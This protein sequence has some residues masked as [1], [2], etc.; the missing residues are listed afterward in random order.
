MG[1]FDLFF[2]PGEAAPATIQRI[3]QVIRQTARHLFRNGGTLGN[4]GH[5]RVQRI[6]QKVRLY[7]QA[8]ML[9]LQ[10]QGPGL[11]LHLGHAFGARGQFGRHAEVHQRPNGKNAHV[12]EERQPVLIAGHHLHASWREH[13][14]DGVGDRRQQ[15]RGRQAQ[16]HGADKHQDRRIGLA[17]AASMQHG[18]R[19]G[20][21][22]GQRF[23]RQRQPDRR[24]S[25]A[26]HRHSD[27]KPDDG[28]EDPSH[29]LGAPEARRRFPL[30]KALAE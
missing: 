15:R 14:M 16:Q 19:A 26:E 25:I 10:L 28:K 12:V 30:A 2:Q 9:Q 13:L 23:Q 11:G 29:D 21:R 17:R 3:A 18:G 4:L 6:E 1:R 24:G 8:Q 22:E 20:H 7:L 27:K 5:D